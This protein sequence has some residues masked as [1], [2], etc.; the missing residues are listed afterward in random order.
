MQNVLKVLEDFKVGDN[1]L[2][3]ESAK[4]AIQSLIS[5]K[6]IDIFCEHI[7]YERKK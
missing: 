5:N 3:G 6:I 2:F 1:I 7:K 4:K